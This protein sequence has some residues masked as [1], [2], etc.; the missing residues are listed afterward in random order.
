MKAPTTI[1]DLSGQI[2]KEKNG[3]K[4]K[5]ISFSTSCLINNHCTWLIEFLESKRRFYKA[6]SEILKDKVTQQ[7]GERQI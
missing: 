3:K 5:V 7:R 4:Y 6:E 1:H 2:I